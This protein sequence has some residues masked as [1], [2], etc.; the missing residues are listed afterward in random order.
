[1][2]LHFV[3]DAIAPVCK[4]ELIRNWTVFPT[5]HKTILISSG[6]V[7]TSLDR[8]SKPPTLH[9]IP[10]LEYSPT[11][12]YIRF[13]FPIVRAAGLDPSPVE[14]LLHLWHSGTEG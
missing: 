7:A 6:V 1:M 11:F 12:V 13:G 3:R 2:K 9:P 8:C 10:I 4:C 5:A 14:T